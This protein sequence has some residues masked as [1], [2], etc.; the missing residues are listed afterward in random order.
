MSIIAT[1]ICAI[2]FWTGYSRE[3]DC[4]SSAHSTQQYAAYMSAALGVYST[5]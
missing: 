4:K 3:G 2:Y 1:V 5:E